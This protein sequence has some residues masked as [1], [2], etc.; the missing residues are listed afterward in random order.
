MK[1]LKRISLVFLSICLLIVLSGC[2]LTPAGDLLPDNSLQSFYEKVSRSQELLDTVGDDIYTYWYDCIYNDKYYD[3]IDIA[4]G[5]ALID[6]EANIEEI[7]ALDAE[8]GQLFQKVKD[9]KHGDKVKAVMTAYS[10]YY[11]FVINV[12]GS[13]NSY[14][15]NLEILKKALASAIRELSYE[16]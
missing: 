5:T 15:E 13:F 14:S 8:I 1:T 2:T 9:G 10:E 3:D 4:I 16:L 7:E 12:S 6:N 11:E